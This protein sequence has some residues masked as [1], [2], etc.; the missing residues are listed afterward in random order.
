MEEIL[1]QL[2][3]SQKEAVLYNDGPSL[4]V[5]GAGSGKT[6]VLTYKIAALLQQGY[7]PYNILAITFTNKAANEM[8]SR[9]ATLTGE[10]TAKQLWMGTFHSIFARILR[11]DGAPLGFTKDYTIYDTDDSKSKIKAIIK[12]LGLNDKDYSAKKVYSR[13]S[14]LKND[15]ITPNAYDKRGDLHESDR[16]QNMPRF[17]EIY[18]TYMNQCHR[19]NAMDFDDI[20][21]YTNV[22]FRDYPDILS[23]Y[24]QLFQFV[25]VDEY[26]DTN[27]SQHLIVK[28]IVDTHHKLC[29]VGDDA[30]SIYSF[31]GANIENILRFKD[32]YPEYKLF[33]LEQNYRSTS[34]IVEAAN[35]LISKNKG[36]IKKHIFSEKDAGN[37][38]KVFSSF[39]DQEESN[40]V[41]NVVRQ[42]S[43][44]Y[45]YEDVAILYRTNAQSRLLEEALRK[46]SIP[47]K[48]HGGKSFYQR[49]IVKD[50]LTYLR[51]VINS[52]D[53]E[54][55]KRTIKYPR[56]GIGDTTLDKIKEVANREQISYWEVISDPVGYNL[57]LGATAIKKLTAFRDKINKF[58]EDAATTDAYTLTDC[59]IKE[60]GIMEDLSRDT[61]E[62]GKDNMKLME[63]LLSGI[64]EFCES[65][66]EEDGIELSTISDY[67]QSVSLLTDQD[68]DKED[69]IHKVTLM[70]VHAAKGLEFKNII[71]VGLEEE[72]FPSD[73]NLDSD[74]GIE[75]ERRL[76]YVAITRAEENCFITYA[77]SRFRNGRT[78]YTSPSRFLS[79]I[80]AQYLDL[81]NDFKLSNSVDNTDFDFQKFRQNGFSH[82]GSNNQFGF[83]SQNRPS[84]T[85]SRDTS[86]ISGNTYDQGISQSIAKP[87]NLKK[88]QTAPTSTSSNTVDCAGDLKTGTN[89]KHERFGIGVITAIETMNS[90]YKLTIQFENIGEKKILLKYAKLEI[91]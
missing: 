14:K 56:K 16:R 38:I 42:L 52:N 26:Q 24:Q 59:I 77:K 41:G 1:K 25:L 22:L 27:F 63:E 82:Y 73:M 13:I 47:Y 61:S 69:D 12:D 35:S 58:N 30:Q 60:C 50:I 32:A 37:K 15:L 29:V 5:A 33:K 34:N 17:K 66:K 4:V 49:K 19:A 72:L 44:D 39:S 2:N 90:D 68:T 51:L 78:M 70:T 7:H 23:K 8:K 43:K 6:R 40:I 75:E 11:V 89:V 76:F 80:D 20:L 91:I 85:S 62:E 28:K 55:F 3:D 86:H 71:V 18:R 88:I 57:D 36:Q 9:I 48:I 21:L 54:A 84:Y 83:N 64:H 45:D 79:D 53:E 67:L 10:H 31:R 46:R 65:R 74:A 81:P 87:T